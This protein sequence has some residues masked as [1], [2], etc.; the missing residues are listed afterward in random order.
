[1]HFFKTVAK[2]RGSHFVVPSNR[3]NS[4]L[5]SE[6]RRTI[7]LKSRQST[8]LEPIDENI[9]LLRF[10]LVLQKTNFLTRQT[11][12]DTVGVIYDCDSIKAVSTQFLIIKKSSPWRIRK[13]Y[14][15]QPRSLPNSTWRRQIYCWLFS[16][17]CRLEHQQ[18]SIL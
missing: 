12:H 4:G 8:I 17:W 6:V 2:N 15:T 13:F 10:W 1:M 9:R 18:W 5:F 7:Q 14:T 3:R 16:S 11:L